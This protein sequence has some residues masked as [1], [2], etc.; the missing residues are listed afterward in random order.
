MRELIKISKADFVNGY[1]MMRREHDVGKT[2]VERT[3]WLKNGDKPHVTEME[4]SDGKT[5]L[6]MH[7]HWRKVKGEYVLATN[8]YFAWTVDT[9]YE[10]DTFQAPVCLECD[11]AC[12]RNQDVLVPMTIEEL[13]ML[14]RGELDW[15]TQKWKGE[16]ILAKSSDG[17]CVYLCDG[18]CILYHGRRPAGCKLWF[19]GRGTDDDSVWRRIS[20]WRSD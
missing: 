11:A 12:C 7:T 2:M 3:G 16:T 9:K 4:W 18:N 1:A 20:E 19:C 14:E 6:V 10:V 15:M 5:T 17:S 13:V 8:K